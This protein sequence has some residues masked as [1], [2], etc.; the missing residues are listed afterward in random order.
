MQT[1]TALRPEGYFPEA[2][3][4]TASAAADAERRF[5]V[6]PYESRQ[7]DSSTSTRSLSVEDLVHQSRA[8][9]AE[10]SD[11]EVAALFTERKALLTKVFAKTATRKERA[12][13]ELVRWHIERIEDAKHGDAFDQFSRLT[14][15]YGQVSERVQQVVDELGR[16]KVLR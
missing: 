12:R 13:L 2:L 6:L 15:L 10:A 11:E 4:T 16:A 3:P 5:V 8:T 7:Q 9:A 14:R 1:A